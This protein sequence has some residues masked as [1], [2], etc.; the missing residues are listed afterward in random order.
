MIN[1]SPLNKLQN[2]STIGIFGFGITGKS[3]LQLCAQLYPQAKIAICSKNIS[4][5]DTSF[6][7]TYTMATI[8]DY[9][10]I[11]TFLTQAD[12]IIP[13][14][15][16]ALSAYPDS[17]HKFVHELDIFAAL[18]QGKT[19]A[20]T[21]SIGKTSTLHLIQHLFLQAQLPAHLAGN[22]GYP[23]ADLLRTQN[24]TDQ[25]AILELSSFQ[26]E[27]YTQ[28]LNPRVAILTNILPNHLDRH[29]SIEAYRSAKYAL[30]N[31]LP[32]NSHALL[33]LSEYEHAAKS[34]LINHPGLAFFTMQQ[35][36]LRQDAMQQDPIKQDAIK[37]YTGSAPL[38]YFDT[39][40][41]TIL[42]KT[43]NN[44]PRILYTLDE[45]YDSFAENWLIALTT[46]Y[47]SGID[48]H[49][50]ST[51]NTTLP[52]HRCDKVAQSGNVTFYNDSKSTII[53]ASYAAIKK[54]LSQHA[55][56][57]VLI[58]GTGKGVDRREFLADFAKHRDNLYVICFGIEHELLFNECQR[59]GL[60]TCQREKL[61][62]AFACATQQ[63]KKITTSIPAKS[64]PS[65]AILFS[66]G[67][68]S[69]DQFA[70][71]QER[72]NAFIALV[73]QYITAQ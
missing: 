37:Q 66:P 11:H 53:Q 24:N 9:E 73:K 7:R 4:Q 14:P 2:A 43:K 6:I 61:A 72:G 34:D 69:F 28:P 47:L 68:A 60:D 30:F 3:L 63:A 17:M 15:G 26:L 31:N 10:N 57:I 59:L 56:T 67:G 40:T 35:D 27:Y 19:I 25:W 71:Y 51:S 64:M 32:H 16:I 22:V 44:A 70:N 21:G 39:P 62:D 1:K 5:E 48:I 52:G 50:L 58:G 65:I 12:C 45:H 8:I 38:F 20:L 49:T 23:L 13:S 29:G 41:N 42:L 33:P 46:C 54:T 18:W 55:Y 36:S